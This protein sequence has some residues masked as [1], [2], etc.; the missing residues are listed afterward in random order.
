MPLLLPN[1]YIRAAPT[2]SAGRGAVSLDVVSMKEALLTPHHT[3]AHLLLYEPTGAPE[4]YPVRYKKRSGAAKYLE[5]QWLAF[6]YDLPGHRAWKDAAEA[7]IQ[8][9]K[10]KAD[11]PDFYAI[12]TT[13]HGLRLI[14]KLPKAYPVYRTSVLYKTLLEKFAIDYDDNCSDW[15]R[16]FRL[17]YVVR[18]GVALWEEPLTELIIEDRVY[19]C[20]VPLAVPEKTVLSPTISSSA[21]GEEVK[22]LVWLNPD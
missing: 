4:I 17:P 12:Y 16:L 2:L 18:D 13:L 11:C 19:D 1:K 14:L 22:K 10:V 5:T 20:E 3:D 7:K 8:I 9:A 6:D 21:P 15:T